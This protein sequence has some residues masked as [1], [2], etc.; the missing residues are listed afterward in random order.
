VYWGAGYGWRGYWGGVRPWWGPGWYG[1]SAYPYAYYPYY[2]Y[3]SPPAVIV[4][5]NPQTYVQQAPPATE[6][7]QP[8]NYWYYCAGSKAYYPYV[9]ECPEGWMTV[10][11]PAS[12]PSPDA[13]R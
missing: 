10:V 11:P 6:A 3:A 2:P 13:G 4:Q 12:S 9:R 1:Y 8:P 7:P 5:P